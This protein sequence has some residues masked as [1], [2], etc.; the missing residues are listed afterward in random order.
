LKVFLVFVAI[1]LA[2]CGPMTI[3]MQNPTTGEIA[4][5]SLKQDRVFG[6]ADLENC[7]RS[8]E[9]AGWKRI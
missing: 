8:Y 7:A 6:S 4:Q 5:C 2:S 9:K 1:G 3:V